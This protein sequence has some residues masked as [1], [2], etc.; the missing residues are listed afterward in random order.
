MMYIKLSFDDTKTRIDFTP[1][2]NSDEITFFFLI[3]GYQLWSQTV[4]EVM[5]KKSQLSKH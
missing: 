2:L 5:I 3:V 4:A 1:G